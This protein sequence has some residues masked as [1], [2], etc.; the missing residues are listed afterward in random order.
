MSITPESV[1]EM[2]GSDDYGQR[3][4]AVNL[5]RQ[6]EPASGYELIRIA[7]DD[8]SAR[9]RYAAV[10]QLSSLGTYDRATSL[11]VLRDRLLTDKEPDVR[12]AAADSIGALQLTEAFEDLKEVYEKTD[13]W[14]IRFSI[15]AA[16]GEL[17][18]ARAF[19]VLESALTS[20]NELVQTAAIGALGE[21]GDQRALPLILPFASDGD[22]QVRYRV[23][24]ALG[25]MTAPEAQQQLETLANDPFEPV[26]LEA[27]NQLSLRH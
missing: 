13:E 4:S 1:R 25:R 26:A 5:I 24:Q 2:L 11:E 14:L 22:W 7:I 12:A 20:D 19:E 9:V 8:S 15:V 10:S 18:D 6:L 16:L 27:K 23:V 17:G 3:L 21:L